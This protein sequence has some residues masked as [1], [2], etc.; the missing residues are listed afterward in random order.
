MK[1]T[2][3]QR[4]PE[5]V[6]NGKLIE[7]VNPAPEVRKAAEANRDWD[8]SAEATKLYRRAEVVM[9]RFYHGI[10]TPNSDGRLPAPLIAVDSMNIRTLAAYLLV[11]DEYG[12]RYKLTFNEQHYIDG[13]QGKAW[14]FGE[15]ALMETLTHELGHHWQ[16]RRGKEPFKNGKVTHNREFTA[17]LEALGIYSTTGHGAHYKPAD[18]DKPFG[19]LMKEWGIT[20][21]E[22]PEDFIEQPKID[23]WK[24][25]EEL[26]GKPVPKGRSSLTKYSCPEC[27]LAVRVGIK[28]DPLLLHDPCSEKLGQKVFFVRAE[29]ASQVIYA[30][31]KES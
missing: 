20:R 7:V 3:N 15:W 25:F 22:A 1:E 27:G 13:D 30:A 26:F 12:L 31:P 19:I 5:S 14:R 11:P 8:Y 18:L 29:A 17:M 4:I 10:P 16:Q 2:I 9:D 21:P 6:K 28:G 23:W 24:F